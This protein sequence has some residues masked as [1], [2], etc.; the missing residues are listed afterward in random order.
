MAGIAAAMVFPQIFSGLLLYKWP[1]LFLISIAGCIIGTYAAP[2]TD[3]DV[4][5]KFYRTVKPWGFWK[6]VHE[7]VVADD[8]SFT[9]NKRFKLDMF[10]VAIGMIAQTCLTILPLYVVLWMKVPL[11]VTILILAITIFILKRTWWNK[12]EN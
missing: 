8:P 9:P 12:L 4:L 2:P 7:M 11:L 3:T 1:L 5:K 6:P 10:N